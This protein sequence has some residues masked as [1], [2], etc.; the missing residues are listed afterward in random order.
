MKGVAVHTL[1][2]VIMMTM[3]IFVGIIIFWKWLAATELAASEATCKAKLLHFC[4]QLIAG[5]DP[6]WEDIPPKTGCE[7]FGVFEPSKEECE[8][9]I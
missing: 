8:R 6:S 4:T 2:I 7:Q 9:L 1:V 5:K 3:F